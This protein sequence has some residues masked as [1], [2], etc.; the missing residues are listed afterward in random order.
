MSNALSQHT[1]KIDR[2]SLAL[3]GLV[4]IVSLFELLLINMT[5]AQGERGPGANGEAAIEQVLETVKAT[6]TNSSTDIGAYAA[7]GEARQAEHQAQVNA[8]YSRHGIQLDED[9]KSSLAADLFRREVEECRRSGKGHQACVEEALSKL[10]GAGSEFRGVIDKLATSIEQSPL[11]AVRNMKPR[12]AAELPEPPEIKPERGPTEGAPSETPQPTPV[13]SP[14]TGP[15]LTGTAWEVSIRDPETGQFRSVGDEGYMVFK[16][17]NPGEP[18][19]VTFPLFDGEGEGS[20]I[21]NHLDIKGAGGG[22]IR[23]DV[24]EGGNKMTGKFY[25]PKTEPGMPSEVDFEAKRKS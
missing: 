4:I 13:L 20:Y 8:F 6:G 19:L 23:A 5:K 9:V 25:F 7:F 21:G 12:T 10:K 1:L 15:D 18:V 2:A 17:G 3:A 11:E 22:I 24:I 16:A 14:G